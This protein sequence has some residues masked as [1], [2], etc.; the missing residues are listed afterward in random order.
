MHYNTEFKVKYKD[1]EE[2]L[3]LKINNNENIDEIG[4]SIEDVL[5]VCDKLYRD[6]LL[7]VF[8]TDNFIDDI[9]EE[10]IKYVY[11]IMISNLQFK[12][13]INDYFLN[14]DTSKRKQSTEEIIKEHIFLIFLSKNFFYIT[15]KCICQ[16][17]KN[18]VIE[19][20]LL[21]KLKNL[22]LN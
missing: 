16:Q 18:G 15:H 12:E 4:Y 19:N 11:N 14:L 2:E 21:V 9:F 10:R 3:I 5:N 1:I 17:I 20:N 22:I 8:F 13:I 6:E 7:S